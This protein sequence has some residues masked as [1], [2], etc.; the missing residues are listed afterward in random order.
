MLNTLDNFPSITPPAS[1]LVPI[2][3]MPCV[4]QLLLSVSFPLTEVH[5][6]PKTEDGPRY[7]G[8]VFRVGELSFK[9]PKKKRA[10]R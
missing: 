6:R 2:S 9:D 4:L 7:F 8:K 5:P 10:W 1:L 3:V